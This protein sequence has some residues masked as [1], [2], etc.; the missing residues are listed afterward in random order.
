MAANP[1]QRGLGC[2]GQPFVRSPAFHGRQ[3]GPNGARQQYA[4]Y[5]C[6]QGTEDAGEDK[7]DGPATK[8]CAYPEGVRGP[9]GLTSRATEHAAEQGKGYKRNGERRVG[10][11]PQNNSGAEQKAQ[12]IGQ[13]YAVALGE[14]NNLRAR[15]H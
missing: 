14:F 10:T 12:P 13:E 6:S 3:P 4:R 9:R 1:E 5:R 8:R 2:K 7:D 15:K 11:E